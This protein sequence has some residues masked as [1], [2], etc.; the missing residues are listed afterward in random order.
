MGKGPEAKSRPAAEEEEEATPTPLSVT[1]RRSKGSGS[2]FSAR[3]LKTV[4]K[5]HIL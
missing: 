4:G 1:C 3:R 5:V 2:S